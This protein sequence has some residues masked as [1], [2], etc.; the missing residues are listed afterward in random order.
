[1]KEP[2]ERVSVATRL[3]R[4]ASPSLRVSDTSSPL[5]PRVVQSDIVN[6][7]ARVRALHLHSHSVSPND[8][9]SPGALKTP[10]SH[11]THAPFNTR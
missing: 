6:P 5:S 3:R 8:G 10:G 1:M 4:S 2:R 7:H 11:A 9:T